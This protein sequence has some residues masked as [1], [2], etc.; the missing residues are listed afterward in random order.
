V[1]ADDAHGLYGG[2]CTL[3]LRAGAFELQVGRSWMYG[4][5]DTDTVRGTYVSTHAGIDLDAR[6]WH[7]C[8][9]ETTVLESSVALARIWH[10]R[11]DGP[12]DD[13]SAILALRFALGPNAFDLLL[14]REGEGAESPTPA[15]AD[16][17]AAACEAR[18]AEADATR[19]RRTANARR[20][21]RAA[22]SAQAF[23]AGDFPSVVALLAPAESELSRAESM[24]LALA[25]QRMKDKE[26]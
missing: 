16:A 6:E 19:Q 7:S 11:H 3:L 4:I 1:D 9:I 21:Q 10:V 26:R 13:P 18:Q 8:T 15:I 25:R 5:E 22:E 23:A 24:R 20:D 2:R 14:L 17:F 12:A